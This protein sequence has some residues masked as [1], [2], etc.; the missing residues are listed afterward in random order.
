MIIAIHQPHYLPWLGYFNKI[1]KADIL[2]FLDTVQFIRN[3]FQNRNRI[4]TSTGPAWLSVPCVHTGSLQTLVEQRIANDVNWVEKHW[5]LITTNYRRAPFYSF[6]CDHLR[7]IYERR[8]D[9]LVELNISLVT[10][11]ASALLINY[12]Y[13]RSSQLGLPDLHKSELL[14]EICR[15]MGADE[16]LSGIGATDYLD[17]EPFERVG[18]R[19]RWQNFEHPRYQQCWASQGF[20]YNLSAIDLLANAG[21][22]SS[23]VLRSGSELYEAARAS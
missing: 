5:N 20:I 15:R 12:T 9:S 11:L 13:V 7:P 2:V 10:A 6:A 18:V 16:Y 23:R 8:F 21:P 3:G 22:D 17:P 19:V 4:K 1:V 14:A